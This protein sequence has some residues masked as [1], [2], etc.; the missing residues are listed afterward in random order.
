MKMLVSYQMYSMIVVG[1]V[2][3]GR[4]MGF[5]SL[6]V[7]SSLRLQ[8]A[9]MSDDKGD[10]TDT[11][12]MEMGVVPYEDLFGAR[13]GNALVKKLGADLARKEKERQ[14]QRRNRG[15]DDDLNAGMFGV[16]SPVEPTPQS[17]LVT[18]DEDNYPDDWVPS[19]DENAVMKFLNDCFIPNEYDGKTKRQAKYVARNITGI[20]FI[21]GVV[22]TVVWY[23]FP[24]KFI[25]YKG[26]MDFTGYG[27]QGT[28]YQPPG[29]QPQD[30]LSDPFSGGPRVNFDDTIPSD[31]TT[32]LRYSPDPKT[33]SELSL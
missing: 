11:G 1:S 24:G 20:S 19:N 26:D 17:A 5:C 25:S 28:A 6:R 21:I 8:R 4:T 9:F 32:G 7:G 16:P 29:L 13:D 3:L 31:K 2:L 18:D 15:S 14:S 23:A 30:L 12:E 10:D 33:P 27:G 22:F